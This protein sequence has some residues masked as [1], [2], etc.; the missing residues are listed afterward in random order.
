MVNKPFQIA[1]SY[2]DT[3]SGLAS[4]QKENARLRQENERLREWYQTAMQLRA[5][6]ESLNKLMHVAIEPE[7]KFVTARVIADSGNSYLKT[8]L[9]MAGM[10]DG[11]SKGQAVI[12]GEGVIGRTVDT[13]NR[14]ARVLLV[15][16][17]NSR[18]PV[19]IKGQGESQDIRAIMAGRNDDMPVIL[20]LPSDAHLS[21]GD[22]V[23]T[24]GNG[25]I[26]PFGLPVGVVQP[27]ADGTLGVRLFADIEKLTYVRIIDRDEEPNLI[28]PAP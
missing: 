8:L 19:I 16:D 3:V 14:A 6:N 12:S 21:S 9:V 11:I 17:I 26:F 7:H 27:L 28:E 10:N 25:G 24:S 18:V 5:E 22:H 2:V 23:M 20:H 13:G 1:A 15:T 4:L